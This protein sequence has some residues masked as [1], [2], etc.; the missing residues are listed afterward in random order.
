MVVG[1]GVGVGVE[2]TVLSA[3]TTERELWYNNVVFDDLQIN[4]LITKQ[5]FANG[6]SLTLL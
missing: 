1:L 3:I 2:D 6:T 4:C 5:H